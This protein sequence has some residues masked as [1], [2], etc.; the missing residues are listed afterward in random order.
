MYQARGLVNT[1][2]LWDNGTHPKIGVTLT[3]MALLAN[4]Q[5]SQMA[6]LSGVP[7]WAVSGLILFPIFI[8][9]ND[10]PEHQVLGLQTIVSY[11]SCKKTSVV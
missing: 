1:G 6:K 3:H 5:W 2:L 10:M 8:Q 7:Q 11:L 9:E 4:Q